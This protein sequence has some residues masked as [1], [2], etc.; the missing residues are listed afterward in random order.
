MTFHVFYPGEG[1]DGY[2][3]R[4]DQE[5]TMQDIIDAILNDPVKPKMECPGVVLNKFKMH[6][7]YVRNRYEDLICTTGYF[8]LDVDNT[9]AITNLIKKTIFD[10]PEVIVSWVSSSGNGVKALGFSPKLMDLKPRVFTMAY[11]VLSVEIRI[12]C[13]MRINF[14][15]AMARCHQPVFINS[16]PNALYKL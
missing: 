8:A 16:D 12:K 3:L 4:Y 10:L 6:G 9:G 1:K 2:Y 5:A 13:G 15:Q 14:D 7:D 11:R